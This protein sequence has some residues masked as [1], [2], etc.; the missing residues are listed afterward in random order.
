MYIYL[1]KKVYGTFDDAKN[2][3]VLDTT[4]ATGEI[5]AEGLVTQKIYENLQFRIINHS[6]DVQPVALNGQDLLWRDYNPETPQI[7]PGKMD[8]EF[9]Y[10]NNYRWTSMVPQDLDIEC[11]P[12]SYLP[13]EILPFSFTVLKP[14]IGVTPV[15]PAIGANANV[16]ISYNELYPA[17]ELVPGD[18]QELLWNDPDDKP[19][20]AFKSMWYKIGDVGLWTRYE[21]PFTVNTNTT[22]FAKTIVFL[23]IVDSF[24]QKA[25]DNMYYPNF[26]GDY[27]SPIES[28]AIVFGQTTTQP[29][30][31][32]TQPPVT[33]APPVTDA[34]V[35]QTPATQPITQAEVPTTTVAIFFPPIPFANV[36]EELP[37]VTVPLGN[38][39]TTN[40]TQESASDLV[41]VEVVTPLGDGTLPQTN[42]LPIALLYGLG[43]LVSGLGVYFVKRKEE[44]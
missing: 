1:D 16:T 30:A 25:L 33:T 11:K 22:I 8:V 12:K 38:L 23:D 14:T 44:E 5:P 39:D 2:V 27:T 41:I 40:A 7:F 36:D 34:P 24:L 13:G 29:P 31:T 43:I 6:P 3:I 42:E 10:K 4:I 15:A 19:Y 37:E 20:I 35:T 18:S 9:R 17:L 21:N 32:T 28:K 26:S